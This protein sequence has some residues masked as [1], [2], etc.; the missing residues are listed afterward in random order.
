M[1]DRGAVF[2]NEKPGKTIGR[3]VPLARRGIHHERQRIQHLR[4]VR[5]SW[6]TPFG[7]RWQSGLI[8]PVSPHPRSP[9]SGYRGPMPTNKLAFLQLGSP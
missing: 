7:R 1:L 8:R 3:V 4:Q 2:G 9:A 5:G 6:T